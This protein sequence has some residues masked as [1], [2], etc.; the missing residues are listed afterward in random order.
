MPLFASS[1]CFKYYYLYIYTLFRKKEVCAQLFDL[2]KGFKF[3]YVYV[4]KE[5]PSGFFPLAEISS[6][7]EHAPLYSF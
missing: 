4:K 7:T 2:E 5:N 3:C 1:P 6:N